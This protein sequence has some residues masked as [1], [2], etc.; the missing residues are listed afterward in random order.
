MPPNCISEPS[1]AFRTSQSPS[2]ILLIR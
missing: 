1:L 2:N